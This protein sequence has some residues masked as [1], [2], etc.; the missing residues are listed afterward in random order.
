MAFVMNAS[1]DDVAQMYSSFFQANGESSV[2]TRADAAYLNTVCDDVQYMIHKQHPH[3]LES[4]LKENGYSAVEMYEVFSLLLEWFYDYDVLQDHSLM[5]RVDLY[6]NYDVQYL[7]RLEG[8]YDELASRNRE[9]GNNYDDGG[10]EDSDSDLDSDS[11]SSDVDSDSDL[12]N[13][14]EEDEVE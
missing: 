4:D 10:D 3:N 12:N 13:N 14:E 5:R 2:I 1:H 8:V 11:D 6:P 9:S 7:E